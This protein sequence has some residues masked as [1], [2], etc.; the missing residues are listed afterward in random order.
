MVLLTTVPDSRIYF[1]KSGIYNIQFSCQLLN[2]TT[3]DDNVTVWF[4]KNNVDVPYSASVQQV[5]PKHGSSPGAAILA[6]NLID[7]FDAGDYFELYWASNTGNTVL[8]TFPAGTAPVHPVSP[9]L[10]LT[11]T[12]VSAV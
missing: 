5:N 11:V 10:I 4:K 2:Y 1:D 9:S 8:A 12:F 6:L 7:S 3:S